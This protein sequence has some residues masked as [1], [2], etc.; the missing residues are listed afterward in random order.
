[1]IYLALLASG[2]GMLCL[3][4]YRIWQDFGFL[5]SNPHEN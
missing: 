1:V 2:K 5:A 3:C 4:T